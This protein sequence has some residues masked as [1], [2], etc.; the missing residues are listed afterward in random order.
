MREEPQSSLFPGLIAFGSH[1]SFETKVIIYDET[2]LHSPG[3]CPHTFVFA[4]Q[5]ANSS[6]ACIIFGRIV[7]KVFSTRSITLFCGASQWRP[8]YLVADVNFVEFNLVV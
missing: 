7:F 6:I 5:A 8:Q 4:R 3:L 2:Y 1:M